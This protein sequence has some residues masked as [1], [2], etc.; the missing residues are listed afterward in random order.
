MPV[1]VDR[2]QIPFR[3]M[4]MCHMVADSLAE[5]HA[6][7]DEIGMRRIWFQAKSFPHYDLSQ[8]RRRAAVI[9]GA[10]EVDRRELVSVMRRWRQAARDGEREAEVAEIRAFLDDPGWQP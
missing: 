5:L 10:I 2:A 7:A 9:M 3:E 6:M 1:Y 4:L 8:P